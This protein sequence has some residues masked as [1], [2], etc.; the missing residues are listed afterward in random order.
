MS[1][2]FHIVTYGCQMNKC[3]SEVLAS[4]LTK[5]GYEYTDKMHDADVVLLN[6]CSVRDTA[7]NKVI[8]RLGRIKHI[9]ESRPDMILGV[10]GCMAQ[11]WG[12]QLVDDFPQVDIV[13]GTARLPELPR[14]IKIYRELGQSVVDISEIPS[15]DSVPHIVR[16]SDLSAWVTIMHGC[17]NFCSYCIVPYVR[18]R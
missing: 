3:D 6:T 8:G 9:K 2:R 7:E 5:S 16:D 10:C 18:G 1:E 17:N 14:L 11:S 13:L 4:I 12:Q 15:D